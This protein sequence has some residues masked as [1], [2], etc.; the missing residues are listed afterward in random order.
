M[1]KE[2]LELSALMLRGSELLRTLA[3]ADNIAPKKVMRLKDMVIE[4]IG[5]QKMRSC[6]V[7]NKLFDDKIIATGLSW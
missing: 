3:G 5:D 7:A 2:L 6:D 1:K 4:A